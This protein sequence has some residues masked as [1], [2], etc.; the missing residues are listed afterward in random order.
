M[1]MLRPLITALTA[2]FA[3]TGALA[4]ATI[5]QDKALAGG[6]TPGDAPGFPIQITQPGSYKLMG[7]LTV[8]AGVAGVVIA[9]QDVTLDLNGFSISSSVTCNGTVGSAQMCSGTSGATAVGVMI[10]APNATLRNGSI[11]GFNADG[12]TSYYGGRFLDLSLTWNAN[13]GLAAWAQNVADL[14]DV[15]LERVR[16]ERNGGSGLV[17]ATGALVIN[18]A[19]RANGGPGINS[20][21]QFT[22]MILDSRI[23]Q[24]YGAGLSAGSHT[25]VRGTAFSGN[26]G[27]NIQGT[28][29]SGGSNLNETTVF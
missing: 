6:I 2:L 25:I 26:Q 23:V 9:A 11:R 29:K 28:G 8:P 10:T 7:N 27:G 17:L 21:N 18:A 14:P 12:V 22:N 4:Q 20:S 3:C 5:T 15:H 13:N 1:N 19:V 16:A 24:N